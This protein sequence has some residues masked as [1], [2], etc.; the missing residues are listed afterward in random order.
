MAAQWHSSSFSHGYL[1]LPT[2]LYLIWTRRKRLALLS[3]APNPWAIPFLLLAVFGWLLGNLTVTGF[4]EQLCVV[5]LMMGLAWGVLGTAVVRALLFPLA[6]LIFAVPFG[7]GLIPWLQDFSAWF[8]VKLLSLTQIPVLLQGRYITVPHGKWE[9]AEVC[10]GVR[11]L[12]S[13]LAVGFVFAGLTYRSWARRIGF[14]CASAIIPI[15]ANGLRIYGII[16]IGYLGGDRLAL[17]VDHIIAGLVFFSIVMLL[18]FIVGLRW[19]EDT[20]KASSQESVPEHSLGPEG[21]RI[22]DQPSYF[23]PGAMIVVTACLFLTALAPI[24]AKFLWG[25]QAQA[26][27]RDL[28]APLVSAPWSTAQDNGFDWEPKFLSPTA[29]FRQTYQSSS[30]TVK[31]Y[32]AY[33]NNGQQGGKLVSSVNQLYDRPRWLR[34]DEGRRRAVIDGQSTEI[35][36]LLAE[37]AGSSLRVWDCYWVDGTLTSSG[38]WAKLLQAKARLF[39]SR[40]GAA[41]IV[42]AAEE[43][44]PGSHAAETLGDFMSHLSVA[45][46][47]RA[48]Q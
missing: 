15:I 16:L 8:A 31:L 29:E 18:L 39:G 3:P 43:P 7:E 26:E 46:G 37:S 14:F 11:Y 38:Y 34:T 9:V 33:Y 21:L 28:A 27:E 40:R 5:F 35:H 23:T 6:F 44:P 4:V 20:G 19:R 1:V 47:F 36:E 12:V 2:S 42:V 32:V 13:S 48:K 30:Q 17:G 41:A 25:R 22:S 24:S 10:S 45:N